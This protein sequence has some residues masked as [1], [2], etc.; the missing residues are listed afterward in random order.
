MTV[1]SKVYVYFT[2]NRT[3]KSINYLH[4]HNFSDL[5]KIKNP[6]YLIVHGK[7][8]M[9]LLELSGAEHFGF[10]PSGLHLLFQY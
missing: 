9:Q 3:L 4:I 8:L 7:Y 5:Y 10:P 2:A 6:L 1:V